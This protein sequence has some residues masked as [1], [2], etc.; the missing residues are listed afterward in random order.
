MSENNA[1]LS[2]EGLQ[3]ISENYLIP[4]QDAIFSIEEFTY[5]SWG[6]EFNTG[7]ITSPNW[8]SLSSKGTQLRKIRISSDFYMSDSETGYLIVAGEEYD[9]CGRPEYVEQARIYFNIQGKIPAGNYLIYRKTN[10]S[11]NWYLLE[12]HKAE[13]NPH[14][15]T[16]NTIGLG[17]VENKSISEIQTSL[18]TSLEASFETSYVLQLSENNPHVKTVYSISYDDYDEVYYGRIDD[19]FPI[20]SW[21]CVGDSFYI[22]VSEVLLSNIIDLS[23]DDDDCGSMKLYIR[24]VS[25]TKFTKGIYKCVITEDIGGGSY[26]AIAEPSLEFLTKSSYNLDYYYRKPSEDLAYTLNGDKTYYIVSG[27]GACKDSE[28]VIPDFYNG[29]PVKEIAGGK[30]GAGAFEKT[31]ISKMVM[32]NNIEKIGSHAFYNCNNLKEV[33]FSK[34]LKLIDSWAFF[35]NDILESIIFNEGLQTIKDNAFRGCVKLKNCYIPIA[36][37]SIWTQAFYGINENATIYCERSSEPRWDSSAK[38]GW[39]RDSSDSSKDWISGSAVLKWN[40]PMPESIVSYP[41]ERL[42]QLENDVFATNSKLPFMEVNYLLQGEK[43]VL[44]KE[45]LLEKG[46]GVY[47]IFTGGTCHVYA[48][49][50]ASDEYSSTDIQNH[51]ITIA[52]DRQ[53]GKLR[54]FDVKMDKGS[55]ISNKSGWS[56]EIITK[57]L[58]IECPSNS[59]NPVWIYFSRV[60][61]PTDTLLGDF[62]TTI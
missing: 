32:G 47:T 1:F 37:E 35:S 24:V 51:T 49:K 31:S 43:L 9:D 55:I 22:N 3:F 62:I 4:E 10:T 15:I 59:T 58:S 14:K 40:Q 25:D 11:T 23:I 19:P 33:V 50:D 17:N 52:V 36:V 42:L 12:S 16:K 54:M 34:S 56:H 5:I 18:K 60:Q 44:T 20:I 53:E 8:Q 13:Y 46:I 21:P 38:T 28:I 45:Q 26:I 2:K 57:N 61:T 39:Y 41:E 30:Q 6:W 48:N 7:F 27:L 29:L